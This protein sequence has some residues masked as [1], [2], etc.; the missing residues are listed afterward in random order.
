ML[1]LDQKLNLLQNIQDRQL[2]EEDGLMRRTL[3]L[4]AIMSLALLVAGGGLASARV[5]HFSNEQ[6]ILIPNF[7]AADHYPSEINV[8]GLSG[9]ITDV[10]VKLRKFTHTF[11]GDVFVMLEGPGGQ[12]V[13]VM[14]DAGREFDVRGIKLVFD[15]EAATPTTRDRAT[16]QGHLPAGQLRPYNPAFRAP[17]PAESGATALSTFDG[18]DP[19]GT[20]K[21]WVFDEDTDDE[22]RF[23][24]GW[25]LHIT[26]G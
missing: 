13:V 14:G 12:N 19:D 10:D 15:D 8:S 3:L 7:G 21:L 5:G 22:G 11:P 23:G 4:V 9:S 2:I 16:Q 20:W 24:C 18:T 25:T 6:T 1:S 17:A 26:T